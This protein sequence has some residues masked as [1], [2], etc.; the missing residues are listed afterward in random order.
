LQV[1]LATAYHRNGLFD[2]AIRCSAAAVTI[3]PSF[4]DGYL[5]SALANAGKSRTDSYLPGAAVPGPKPSP[6]AVSCLKEAVRMAS[7]ALRHS[8]D[9]APAYRCRAFAYSKLDM[10]AEA[11][12]DTAVAERLSKN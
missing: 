4:A 1:A 12:A 7:Q 11:N 3:A 5:A 6:L 2:D 10:A 8:P 9:S